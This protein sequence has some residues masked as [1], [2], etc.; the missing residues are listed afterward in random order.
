[1]RRWRNPSCRRKNRAC[2]DQRSQTSSNRAGIAFGRSNIL[3][4][5]TRAE[6]GFPVVGPSFERR[7]DQV[8]QSWDLETAVLQLP[9]GLAIDTAAVTEDGVQSRL[10][11][12]Q[13]ADR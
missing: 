7:L 1:M 2:F 12:R 8:M 4:A 13:V 5:N 3:L 9:G 11:R 10:R 6:L